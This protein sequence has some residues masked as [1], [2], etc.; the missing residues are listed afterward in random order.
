[1]LFHGSRPRLAGERLKS[2]AAMAIVAAALAAGTIAGPPAR[3]ADM[4][5]IRISD[6]DGSSARRVDLGLGK[7]IIVDL[8]HDAKE[9]FVAN[10]AVANAVVR[11]ARKVFVIAAAAGQ[12][13]I[14]FM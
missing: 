3:A 9:V 4:S 11:S 12:T 10:P 1:M 2:A 14:F 7:S 6:T 13:S 8:P 5:S